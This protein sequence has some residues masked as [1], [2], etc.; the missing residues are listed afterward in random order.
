M[1]A[2]FSTGAGLSTGFERPPEDGLADHQC[3]LQG[4]HH[5]NRMQMNP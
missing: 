5:T 3:G 1:R 4:G 2:G